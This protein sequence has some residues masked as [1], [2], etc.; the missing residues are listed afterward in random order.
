MKQIKSYECRAQKRFFEISVFEDS[1]RKRLKAEL[2]GK[3]KAVPPR[4]ENH[5]TIPMLEFDHP[6]ELESSD[7][8]ELLA[9]VKRRIFE[10]AGDIVDFYE[11]PFRSQQP[12][13]N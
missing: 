12:P 13:I 4:N 10:I 9:V 6:E 7:F 5:E 8:D 3:N 1:T 11:V 2:L